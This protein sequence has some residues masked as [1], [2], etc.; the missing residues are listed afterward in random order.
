M[1]K[2]VVAVGEFW[3]P[4]DAGEQNQIDAVALAGGRRMAVLAGEA[5]WAREVNGDRLQWE[6]ER[7]ASQLPAVGPRLRYAVCARDRVNTTE[8]E[9]LCITA[10]DIF[11][12]PE[13][14]PAT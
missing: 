8:P 14:E 7:K 1:G 3:R 13:D 6:L 11:G 9:L 4:G 2:D 12:L 5:K 10:R